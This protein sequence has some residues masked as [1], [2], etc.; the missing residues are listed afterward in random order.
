MQS[1][2]S[3]QSL[4]KHTQMLKFRIAPTGLRISSNLTG[5][6]RTRSSLLH[7]LETTSSKRPKLETT[8]TIAP[9]WKRPALLQHRKRPALFGPKDV[10]P[11]SRR[12]FGG[13]GN[14]GIYTRAQLSI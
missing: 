10:T 8:S 11:V 5:K 3:T 6:V 9:V 4:D 12:A 1:S 14:A 7:A 13:A 2:S